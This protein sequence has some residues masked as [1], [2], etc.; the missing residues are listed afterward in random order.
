[1]PVQ[2]T[3]SE[4]ALRLILTAIASGIIGFD[5]SEHD[6]PAGLR[7]VMLVGLAASV[8]MV[9]VNLLMPTAGRTP[10]S[11][12]VLDLARWPLG[13]LTGVGFI[14]GGAI[15]RRGDMV[16]GLTTA[17]TLW[18]V[19]VMGLCFGGGQ[20]A[21]GL[22]ALLLGVIVLA[23]LKWAEDHMKRDLKA[24]LSLSV[25]SGEIEQEVGGHLR[26][27]GYR[28]KPL[29]VEHGGDGRRQLRWEIHW[30]G[31]SSDMAPRP[32]IEEIARQ[33]GVHDVA[34]KL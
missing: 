18:F 13:I 8:A 11:F 17:A 19:T 5:R 30:L 29:G 31:T 2:I 34:W 27:A 22:V 20:I 33:S 12:V 7:T 25:D 23:A 4:I 28:V 10:D 24:N 32:A 1:M 3:W 14:G 16:T 15:L 26:A 21:L 9:Q 6:R